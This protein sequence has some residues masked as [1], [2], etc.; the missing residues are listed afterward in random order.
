MIELYLLVLNAVINPLN[1][2]DLENSLNNEDKEEDTNSRKSSDYIKKPLRTSSSLG[3]IRNKDFGG[4]KLG[5][6]INLTQKKKSIKEQIDRSVN[7]TRDNIEFIETVK[8][9]KQMP[10]LLSAIKIVNLHKNKSFMNCFAF[11][12]IILTLIILFFIFAHNILFRNYSNKNSKSQEEL[13]KI[14]EM[15]YL[16]TD[17]LLNIL[18]LIDIEIVVFWTQWVFFFIFMKEFN[19]IIDF[20][21]H[22]YWSIFVKSYFS[23][24]TSMS[25]IILYLL[26]ESDTVIYLDILYVFIYFFIGLIL[27]IGLVIINYIF[28]ELPLKKLFRYLFGRSNKINNNEDFDLKEE[29]DDKDERNN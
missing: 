13:Q 11:I 25:P 8:E 18:Y 12:L 26:Y 16:I 6:N 29:E 27:I 9:I 15:E 1:M 7:F 14:Y 20:F 23:F 4:K 10:F 24:L 21:S 5:E 19:T 17:K 28:F 3:A 22:I 2:F